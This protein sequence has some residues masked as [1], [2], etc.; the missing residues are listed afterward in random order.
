MLLHER[1]PSEARGKASRSTFAHSRQI[2]GE[3]DKGLFEDGD[4]I[5]ACFWPKMPSP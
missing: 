4:G 2:S 1:G 3:G 5:A